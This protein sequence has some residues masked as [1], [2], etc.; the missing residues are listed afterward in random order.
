MTITVIEDIIKQRINTIR[1]NTKIGSRTI[2][3]KEN[4]V[5]LDHIE[6]NLN[7]LRELVERDTPMK[8]IKEVDKKYV[9]TYDFYERDIYRCGSCK[10]V[11]I[12]D[13]HQKLQDNEKTNY[14]Y[15][16][17]QKLLW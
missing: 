7:Q 17:G 4:A 5:L 1:L 16:C 8:V 3:D 14:C 13:R 10:K 6:Y 11:L 12:I 9:D 15:Y 2:A